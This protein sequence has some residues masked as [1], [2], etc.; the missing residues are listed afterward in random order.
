[1]IFQAGAWEPPQARADLRMEGGTGVRSAGPHNEVPNGATDMAANLKYRL[2]GGIASPILITGMELA[3]CK[4]TLVQSAFL[5]ADI[6]TGK[7]QPVE[8]T[9]TQSAGL[10]RSSR[11]YT[12]W[13]LKREPERAA[14][15][16]G[17]LPL[18][19]SQQPALPAAS[20]QERIFAFAN[21]IGVFK[22][23]DTLGYRVIDPVN[24]PIGGVNDAMQNGTMA[25]SAMT[26][27][28]ATNG[29]T[30]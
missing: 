12:H 18:V 20:E 21:E 4:R 22:I 5:S 3:H 30:Y 8:F 24:T 11:T 27:G 17:L 2:Y 1:M 29:V 23:L 6:F 16:A 9:Q 7:V 13:A 14:I 25:N 28:A 15:E 26:N 10:A 19:P